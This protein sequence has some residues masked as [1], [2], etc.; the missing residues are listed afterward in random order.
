MKSTVRPVSA[1]AGDDRHIWHWLLLAALPVA[2]VGGILLGGGE[3][4]LFNADPTP[5]QLAS[6][7]DTAGASPSAVRER[8]TFKATTPLLAAQIARQERERVQAASAAAVVN[9][10]AAGPV[11]APVPRTQFPIVPLAF[12]PVDWTSLGLSQED[13]MNVQALQYRFAEEIGEMNPQD[14]EYRKRWDRAQYLVDEELR[15]RLGW[16]LFSRY[17]LA[18][19]QLP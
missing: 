8:A 13:L 3:S 5:P 12:R 9:A 18:A 6:T 17:Q 19:S 7:P 15:A 4:L 10:R 2:A 14:P 16:T 1:A 11:S